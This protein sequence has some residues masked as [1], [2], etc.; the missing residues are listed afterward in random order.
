MNNKRVIILILFFSL[1]LFPNINAEITG[2]ASSQN[3]GVSVF[4]L[5]VPFLKIISPQNTTY[6]E[7]DYILLDYQANFMDY[8]WYNF[9]NTANT[10]ISSSFYFTAV[11]GSHT[12]YLYGNYS[13]GTVYSANV[14][15]YVEPKKAVKKVPIN[16]TIPITLEKDRIN[17]SLRQGESKL[18][19][20][21]IINNYDEALKIDLRKTGLDKLLLNIS[22]TEFYLYPGES[23]EI[24]LNFTAPIDFMPDLYLGSL[25]V[26]TKNSEKELLISVEVESREFLLDV[27]VD[28]PKEPTIFKPGEELTAIINF[29]NLGRLGE[30][31]AN[32]E[33]IIKDEQGNIVFGE[34]QILI[35]GES[36]S[37]TKI[38]RLP[39]NIKDGNYIFYVKVTYENKIAS[40]SKWFTVLEKPLF[41][42]K[43]GEAIAKLIAIIVAEYIFLYILLVLAGLR[44]FFAAGKRKKK[45]KKGTNFRDYKKRLRKRIR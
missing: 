14:T 11:V 39:D 36:V 2:K 25:F 18:V 8:V 10:T 15:F 30:T 22:E 3:T 42:D 44:C 40:A 16:E 5:P 32:V 20:L 7:G 4:V 41:L 9:D 24:S 43:Y 19:D 33:Y 38:L 21:L 26:S 27:T 29:Y 37:F 34:K 1:L 6:T 45:K 12:L 28:I 35:I 23:K 31:E 17:V 13:N